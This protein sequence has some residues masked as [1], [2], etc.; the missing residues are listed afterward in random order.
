[1]VKKGMTAKAASRIQS[2]AD[3]TG[4]NQGFKSRATAAAAKNK[5]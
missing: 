2:H 4:T 1:M 5:K 3:K